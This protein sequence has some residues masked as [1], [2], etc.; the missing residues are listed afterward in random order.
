MKKVLT[1]PL[2]HF[3]V[4]GAA[5][6]GLNAWL[7][8]G[9]PGETEPREV[10]ISEG[11]VQWLKET[12][13]RQW[14]REPTR[15]EF[16]ELLT[17]FL[18]EELLARE[19][20]EMGLDE[21]D[22]VVR[23]RLAQKVEFLVKDTARLVEPSEDELRRFYDANRER[24]Q[25]VERISFTQLLFKTEAGAREGLGALPARGAS[26]IG[27]ATLLAREHDQVDALAVTS[28]FGQ[29]FT[30]RVFALDVGAWRGPIASTYGFHLVK[31]NE[32]QAAQT[33]SFDEV[34][35]VLLDEWQRERQTKLYEEYVAGLLEKYDVVI[36]ESVESLMEVAQ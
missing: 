31:I 32:R 1:E 34:R 6:F 24:Y 29:E 3:L 11:D 25:D 2:L 20:L 28:Q 13:A 19:A 12:W 27:D 14:Q 26:G 16:R 8:R 30:E 7:N 18:R 36:A 4:I 23:R 21:N 10:H 33:V 35:D 15:E 22:T 5:L 9:A 17:G